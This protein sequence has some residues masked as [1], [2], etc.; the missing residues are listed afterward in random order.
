MKRD[1]EEMDREYEDQFVAEV[2]PQIMDSED[3]DLVLNALYAVY[4]VEHIPLQTWLEIGNQPRVYLFDDRIP[5]PI[6][7]FY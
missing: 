7:L 2:P 4:P 1:Y 3:A 5:Q 6:R